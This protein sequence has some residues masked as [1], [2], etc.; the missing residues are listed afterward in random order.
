ML[1]I[2]VAAMSFIVLTVI[3]PINL[4]FS[5]GDTI[6]EGKELLLTF[7]EWFIPYSWTDTDDIKHRT[8]KG[9]AHSTGSA[10]E[11]G[12]AVLWVHCILYALFCFAGFYVIVRYYFWALGTQRR[13]FIA[14]T[15]FFTSSLMTLDI[16]LDL[17]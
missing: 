17:I 3:L 9:F 15:S 13:N 10:I 11:S 5:N 12:S 1:C 6:N 4:S 7:M 14:S 16:C 8:T 2:L